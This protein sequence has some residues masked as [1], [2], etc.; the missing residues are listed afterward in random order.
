M[1][2][3]NLVQT[4]P[5]RRQRERSPPLSAA[6]DPT[7]TASREPSNHPVPRPPIRSSSRLRPD[8]PSR[9]AEAASP[10]DVVFAS[11][12]RKT[13]RKKNHLLH[14][15]THAPPPSPS[16]PWRLPSPNPLLP[17]FPSTRR[18]D[19]DAATPPTVC[20]RHRT[21]PP[22]SPRERPWA[23]AISPRLQPP[24]RLASLSLPFSHPARSPQLAHA[25]PRGRASG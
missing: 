12:P 9:A 24:A 6:A 10:V 18:C 7:P 5:Q 16:P 8:A 22:A 4:T 14:A 15:R 21:A 2:L 19:A 3:P 1:A 11:K 25:D 23:A 17:F 13:P 20:Q